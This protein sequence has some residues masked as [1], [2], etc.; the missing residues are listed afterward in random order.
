MAF[1]PVAMLSLA[2]RLDH[3]PISRLGAR[4]VLSSATTIVRNAPC[5][6]FIRLL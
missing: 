4:V 3:N 1:L 5:S 6:A 2:M